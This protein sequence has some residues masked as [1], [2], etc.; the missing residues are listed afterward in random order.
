MCAYAVGFCQVDDKR[1]VRHRGNNDGDDGGG[2]VCWLKV[3]I[4]THGS[5]FN[6]STSGKKFQRDDD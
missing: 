3:L 4:A 1:I 5:H 6:S 2:G